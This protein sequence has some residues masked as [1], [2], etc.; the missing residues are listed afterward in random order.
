[1]IPGLLGSSFL[2]SSM[3]LLDSLRWPSSALHRREQQASSFA[4]KA[5]TCDLSDAIHSVHLPEVWPCRKGTWL[6]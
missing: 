5:W 2:L 3:S 1:M 6:F 4:E